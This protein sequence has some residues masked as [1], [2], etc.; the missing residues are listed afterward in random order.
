MIGDDESLHDVDNGDVNDSAGPI[1]TCGRH[2]VYAGWLGFSVCMVDLGGR[3]IIRL[4][5]R[6]VFSV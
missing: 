5:N 6:I 2:S 3:V 1:G 4:C